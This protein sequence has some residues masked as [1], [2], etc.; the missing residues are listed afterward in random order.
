M[1]ANNVSPRS[2]PTS[3]KAGNVT[4]A[5][6]F[7]PL[8]VAELAKGDDQCFTFDGTRTVCVGNRSF[9]LDH[10]F[11]PD[12]AQF[13]VY[14]AVARPVVV[15]VLKGYNGTVMAYGQTG[16]GKTHTME[17]D[18]GG[19]PAG[20]GVVPR[21]VSTLFDGVD[22]AGDGE[23]FVLKMSAVEIYME[24]I[25]DLLAP[26]D[27]AST[28]LKVHED[29]LLGV[30]VDA[31]ERHAAT[32]D[33]VY[34][35]AR[36]A[37]TRRHIAT[38]R[39]NERSSRSHYIFMLKFIARDRASLTERRGVLNLVDLAGS[40]NV[41]QSG[42]EGHTL[43][44]AKMINRSLSSLGNV[45]SA[46]TDGR[47]QHVPYRDSKLTRVLQQSLG[48]NAKTALIITCSPAACNVMESIST[49]RFGVRAKNIRNVPKVNTQKSYGQLLLDLEASA[50]RIAKLEQENTALKGGRPLGQP[51]LVEALRRNANTQ[52]EAAHLDGTR[53]ATDVESGRLRGLASS[54]TAVTLLPPGAL[55]GGAPM[56]AERAELRQ[57]ALELR[58]A[59]SQSRAAER[60]TQQEMALWR[61]R[62]GQLSVDVASLREKEATLREY[63]GMS[64]LE[65]GMPACRTMHKPSDTS[66]S[67]ASGVAGSTPSYKW[68]HPRLTADSFSIGEDL[69]L[70]DGDAISKVEASP[71]RSNAADSEQSCRNIRRNVETPVCRLHGAGLSAHDRFGALDDNHSYEMQWRPPDLEVLTPRLGKSPSPHGSRRASSP[72]APTRSVTFN[73][74]G[75]PPPM[76]HRGFAW[77]VAAP[78]SM[79]RDRT[80]S[81]MMRDR[82]NSGS[83]EC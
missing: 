14:E 57:Q 78:G 79:T 8:N 51:R 70:N 64:C 61:N 36:A 29:A 58:E 38:T 72:P 10:V 2:V 18:L 53:A 28:N 44:E 75:R 50:A 31:V 55:P 47:S 16:S 60:R 1:V 19:E 26:G 24:R 32:E 20:H 34:E 54:P 71:G 48:G 33:D 80:N 43:E 68:T 25:C 37:H 13:E 41:G 17:G 39:M 67:T 59:L 81:G 5:C 56:D 4:V 66:M 42:A 65:D 23:E 74:V 52:T 15:D 46:L 82:T 7:R 73:D 21:M 76:A 77:P 27:P 83:W 35:V 12:T 11:R 62:A 69:D 6:R 45:I 3:Q 22:Q 9:V 40:E 63:M 30:R 49:L